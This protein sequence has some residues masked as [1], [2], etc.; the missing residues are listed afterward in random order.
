LCRVLDG[1]L[2]DDARVKAVKLAAKRC[3]RIIK[4]AASEAPQ[5]I[6]EVG[7]GLLNIVGAMRKEN[8]EQAAQLKFCALELKALRTM[9]EKGRTILPSE[10]GISKSAG[11]GLQL[12]LGSLRLN[13]FCWGVWQR[14]HLTLVNRT[15]KVRMTMRLRE[16]R[17]P[18]GRRT[19]SR[20][21]LRLSL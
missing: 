11:N 14:G 10:K 13:L 16:M 8:V 5:T 12:S 21:Y 9:V 15:K 2:V 7:H 3:A 19:L 17:I 6:A 4:I 1:N 20:R 18:R